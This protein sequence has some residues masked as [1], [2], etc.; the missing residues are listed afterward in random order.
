MDAP[1]TKVVRAEVES[2]APPTPGCGSSWSVI[3]NTRFIAVFG[4][5]IY[6]NQFDVKHGFSDGANP[7]IPDDPVAAGEYVTQW[8][9]SLQRGE[10]S[11]EV[12]RVG[13][14]I[15]GYLDL[16]TA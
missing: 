9:L 2:C 15:Y 7:P 3:R 6:L 5:L 1:T 10:L 11:S 14:C 4:A 13:T 8:R 16:V 12:F